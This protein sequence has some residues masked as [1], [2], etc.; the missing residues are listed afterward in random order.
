MSIP[1]EKLS[2]EKRRSQ[3]ICNLEATLYRITSDLVNRMDLSMSGYVRS[4]IITDL[5]K[6]GLLPD[7]IIARIFLRQ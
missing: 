6:R 1:P 2:T 3:I 7:S 4:L 5:Q